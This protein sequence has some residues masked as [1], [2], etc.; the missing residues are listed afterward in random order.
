MS[1][2]AAHVVMPL[3]LVAHPALIET[4]LFRRLENRSD[5]R[6]SAG[7]AGEAL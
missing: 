1:R 4:A 5:G 6:I 3:N 2:G 7:Q